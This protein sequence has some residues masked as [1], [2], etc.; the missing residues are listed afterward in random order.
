MIIDSH[1]HFR[2]FSQRNVETIAHGLE[3]ARDTGLSAVFDMPNTDPLITNKETLRARLRLAKDAN[4][5]QV[6][7]GV[8]LGLT[9]DQEQ[10]KRAIDIYRSDEF[11]PH[12]VGFKLYAGHS[13][14]DLAV[15]KEHEQFD[16][17]EALAREEFEGV[18]YVHAEKELEIDRSLFDKE[19]PI[20]HCHAQ[21]YQAEVESIKD[22]LKLSAEAGYNGK[23]HIAHISHPESVRIVNEAKEQGRDISSGVC[24]HHVLYSAEDMNEEGVFLKMNPPLRFSPSNQLML[25]E[26]WEGRIDYLETDHAPHTHDNKVHDC[27]SGIPALPWWPMFIQYLETQNFSRQQIEDVTFNNVQKRFGIDISLN[28]KRVREGQHTRDYEFNPFRKL[29][30]QL[31]S[32]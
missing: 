24:P 2:D 28:K 27:A 17:Y 32:A 8:Y 12:V 14:G 22:Q 7:Y 21:P 26:L 15:V 6:F 3:V 20:T 29:E 1:V 23:I 18:V 5:P 4:V 31:W 30:Q 10:V 16:V 9:A 11:S 25:G 19:N 13:T